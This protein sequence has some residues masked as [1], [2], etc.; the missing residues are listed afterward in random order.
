MCTRDLTPD[1]EQLGNM[2]ASVTYRVTVE[3]AY[4]KNVDVDF[5]WEG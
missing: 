3:L 5:C 2:F 1:G 4:L